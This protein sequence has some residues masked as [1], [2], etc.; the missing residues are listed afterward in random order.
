MFWLL[1][2][3]GGGGGGGMFFVFYNWKKKNV[4]AIAV[5]CDFHEK[6]CEHV[7]ISVRLAIWAW[8]KLQ[9]QNIERK[10]KNKKQIIHY[11]GFMFS[12]RRLRSTEPDQKRKTTTLDTCD[13]SSSVSTMT[14]ICLPVS[15]Q[16]HVFQCQQN[17]EPVELSHPPTE[18]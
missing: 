1:N 7:I 16:W 8:Y 17:D 5:P 6:K 14:L 2:D 11:G 3:W 13:M 15:A 18:M 4:L 12:S 9:G 10:T